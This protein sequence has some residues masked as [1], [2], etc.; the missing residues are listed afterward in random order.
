MTL[1]P[2][3]GWSGVKNLLALGHVDAAGF[4]VLSDRRADLILSGGVNLYPAEIEAAL[5]KH[6][7]VREVA[8]VGAPDIEWGERIVAVVVLRP[9]NEA[10]AQELLEFAAQELP[11]FVRPEEVIFMEALPKN[12]VGKIDKQAVRRPLWNGERQ[13]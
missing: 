12:A 9:N 13:V 3:P 2:A 10:S 11:K 4:L 6:P 7:A 5:A 1:S 8:V